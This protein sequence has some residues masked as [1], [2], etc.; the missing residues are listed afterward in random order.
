MNLQK[1]LFEGKILENEKTLRLIF[2]ED[3]LSLGLKGGTE[4][5]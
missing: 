5:K 1:I 3:A 2:E 4:R